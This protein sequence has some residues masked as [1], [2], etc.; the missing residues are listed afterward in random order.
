M[1]FTVNSKQIFLTYPQCPLTRQ[2]LQQFIKNKFGV[3]YEASVICQEEHEPTEDDNN[4]GLH[5][6]AY[7]LLKKQKHIRNCRFFDIE[8]EG[9]TYHPNVQSVK[10]KPSV[11]RYVCKSDMEILQDNFDV[12]SYIESTE[13]KQAYGFIQAAKAIKEGKTIRELYNE[14]PQFVM[15]H[16]RKIED[17]IQLQHKFKREKVYPQ[18]VPFALDE[19]PARAK[20]AKFVNHKMTLGHKKSLWVHGLTQTGKSTLLLGEDD[21]PQIEH[22]SKYF[23]CYRWNTTEEK[24][25][26]DILECDFIVIDEFK[27]QIKIGELIQLLDQKTGY[28][29]SIKGLSAVELPK[30]IPVFITGQHSPAE[31]YKN[32]DT[33]SIE[34]LQRRL[35]IVHLT[36]QYQFQRDEFDDEDPLAIDLSFREDN[37]IT[38]QSSRLLLGTPSNSSEE[39]K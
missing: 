1:S 5:L 27:G 3:H 20:Y 14:A 19:D 11:I 4:T 36:K 18:F 23:R 6:H 30:K 9:Q 25:S 31:T 8:H 13:K 15:N 28:K 33:M 34:A 38:P 24:Q 12:E 37:L 16:K 21:E 10:S 26:S 7:V 22:L 35:V 2:H 32:V 39:E 29:V 17:Y